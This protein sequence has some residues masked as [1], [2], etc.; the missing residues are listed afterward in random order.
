MGGAAGGTFYG[1]LVGRSFG[2]GGARAY[3]RGGRATEPR[4]YH[5]PWE[6]EGNASRGVLGG[7]RDLSGAGPS[8]VGGNGNGDS[9]G[10][11]Q[12]GANGD[13]SRPIGPGGPSGPG[14]G[15]PSGLEEAEEETAEIGEF[16]PSSLL[17]S[18]RIGSEMVS[19]VHEGPP[20]KRKARTLEVLE[21]ALSW[22][23]Y[24]QRMV[25]REPYLRGDFDESLKDQEHD[26]TEEEEPIVTHQRNHVRHNN[27]T[28]HSDMLKKELRAA[29]VALKTDE[30]REQ[31]KKDRETGGC[32]L[33]HE[34]G[35]NARDCPNKKGKAA[36]IRR[37]EAK[38]PRA[39]KLIFKFVDQPSDAEASA[40][41]SN[42]DDDYSD[43]YDSDS[44]QF[45]VKRVTAIP[46]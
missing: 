37:V 40:I 36:F 29:L 41:S 25:K 46:R 18:R 26:H 1:E 4:W 27:Q 14:G 20:S 6:G 44:S 33:C 19:L 38:T 21:R 3:P 28:D 16:D 9:G 32:F 7:R 35:N 43:G 15:G 31:K 10:P 39:A 42:S 17:M 12:G 8:G 34:Q 11:G 22:E 45:V 24:A 30:E 23:D 5:P 13:Q 2:S